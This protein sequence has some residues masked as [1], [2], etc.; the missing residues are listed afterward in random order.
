VSHRL[1]QLTPTELTP[2]E[3]KD[4]AR[5]LGN[6]E[7]DTREPEVTSEQ[8]EAGGGVGDEREAGERDEH[9]PSIGNGAV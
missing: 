4:P 1:G 2:T 5:H 8:R 9:A 3:R 6:H 7:T